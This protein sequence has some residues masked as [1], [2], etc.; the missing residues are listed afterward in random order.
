MVG[1]EV[2]GWRDVADKNRGTDERTTEINYVDD[3]D[4]DAPSS[5]ASVNILN[6]SRC[7]FGNW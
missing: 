3:D 4:D 6:I 1:V 2:T 7:L 5:D